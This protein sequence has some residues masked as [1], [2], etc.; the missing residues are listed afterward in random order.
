MGLGYNA[1]SLLHTLSNTLRSQRTENLNLDIGS[2]AYQDILLTVNELAKLLGHEK[3]NDAWVRIDVYSSISSKQAGLASLSLYDFKNELLQSV[4]KSTL[5]DQIFEKLKI[6][7]IDKLIKAIETEMFTFET[8]KLYELLGCNHHCI[9]IVP[10]THTEIIHDLNKPVEESLYNSF[11]ITLDGGT[12]EHCFNV[13]QVLTNI[14]QMTRVGGA[15]FHVAPLTWPNHGFYNFNPCLFHEFYSANGFTTKR[16]LIGFN[17]GE[18][19][20]YEISPTDIFPLPPPNSL[21]FFIASK[22]KQVTEITWPIQEIYKHLVFPPGSG[23]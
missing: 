8:S 19:P 9:D 15:V 13:P 17:C 16:T 21:L 18:D 22:D 12:L 10:H 7:T 3:H 20:P 14:V 4:R 1:L 5:R 2:L 23:S 11:D 6:D